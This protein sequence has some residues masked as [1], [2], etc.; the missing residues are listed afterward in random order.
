MYG[1]IFELDLSLIPVHMIKYICTDSY[2]EIMWYSRY[3]TKAEVVTYPHGV[4]RTPKN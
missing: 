2:G 4:A 1:A 3:Q